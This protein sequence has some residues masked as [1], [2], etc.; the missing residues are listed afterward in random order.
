MALNVGSHSLILLQSLIVR[1]IKLTIT[2]FGL[3]ITLAD[4][5]DYRAESILRVSCVSKP[6]LD[7]KIVSD[8]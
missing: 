6:D 1:S 5:F 3:V 7:A 2:L 4:I 8:R